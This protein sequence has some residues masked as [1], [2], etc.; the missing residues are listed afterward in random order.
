MTEDDEKTSDER[1]AGRSDSN[2]ASSLAIDEGAASDI[3]AVPESTAGVLEALKSADPEIFAQLIKIGSSWQGPYPPPEIF[4][5][6]PKPLQ[7]AI[8]DN[9][10]DESRH[11]RKIQT[12][13]QIAGTVIALAAI[14][15]AVVTASMGQ[16]FVAGTIVL[17]TMGGI[18]ATGLIRLFPWK[19]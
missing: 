17:A 9:L 7:T 13:G 18:A 11:R 12:R 8:K 2:P 4:K 5:A 15:G 10:I 3:D 14:L 19:H 1:E 16:P 6:Y